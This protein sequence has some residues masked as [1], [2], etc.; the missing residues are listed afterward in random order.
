MTIST[1]DEE[2]VPWVS[3]AWYALAEYREIFWIRPHIYLPLL[4]VVV[5]TP[6]K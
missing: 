6:R 1:A 4:Q 3:P 2:G 5:S